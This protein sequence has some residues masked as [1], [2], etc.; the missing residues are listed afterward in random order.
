MALVEERR[1]Q[2]EAWQ[3]LITRRAEFQRQRT[4]WDRLPGSQQRAYAKHFEELDAAIAADKTLL[5]FPFAEQVGFHT[6][7]M[8]AD[9]SSPLKRSYRTKLRMAICGNRAGKTLPG[10]IEL[11]WW[12]LGIHPYM[13]TPLPPFVTWDMAIDF[14]QS[15]SISLPIFERF[16][17]VGST[18]HAKTRYWKLPNGSE[19]VMRSQQ[20]GREKAQ[21]ANVPIIAWDEEGKDVEES[22]EIYGECQPRMW[23]AAG[24]MVMTLTPL[25]GFPWI[26][27][28]AKNALAGDQ[29]I[30]VHQWSTYQNPYIPK[31]ELEGAKFDTDE[32]RQV[33]LFGALIPLGIRCIFNKEALR[34]Q[35]DTAQGTQFQWGK[36]D[37]TVDESG[38]WHFV[39]LTSSNDPTSIKIFEPPTQG[40]FYIAGVDT[41]GGVGGN[42]SVMIVLGRNPLRVVA[43]LRSNILAIPEFAGMCMM[44]GYAYRITVLNRGCLVVPEANN[45]GHGLILE[46]LRQRYDNLW[47]KRPEVGAPER[48]TFPGWLTTANTKPIIDSSVQTAIDEESIELRDTTIIEECLSYRM[49]GRGNTGAPKG[50]NDD[51]VIALGISLSV[52]AIEPLPATRR[53]SVGGTRQR[54]PEPQ[55][56]IKKA[57]APQWRHEPSRW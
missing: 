56:L 4:L 5:Y 10:R 2:R 17:P 1:K 3:A 57:S 19:I 35:L 9:A 6:S 33:R 15:E 20:S 45:H 27:N 12:A 31:S 54:L 37:K 14:D 21:S 43:V 39:R 8:T 48:N 42:Y 7:R 22:R 30:E 55:R 32:E 36:I 52:H 23:D 46:M 40:E 25:E 24:Q 16:V 53:D 11:L 18:W 41:S 13:F 44:L 34:R 47:T 38:R 29:E 26:R 51:T 49:D 28:L 50:E